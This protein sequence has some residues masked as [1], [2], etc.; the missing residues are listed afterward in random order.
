MKKVLV[1][2]PLLSQSGYGVHARQIFQFC[3]N[4]PDWEVYTQIL[5]WGITPWNISETDEGGI[6]NRIMSVS[7]APVAKFDISFQVQLPHEWDTSLADKNVG[8]TAGVETNLCSTEW[9]NT[10]RDKMDLLIVPSEFTKS[11]LKKCGS[12]S[13]KTPIVVLPEAYF[14][15][16]T[17]AP[18]SDPLAN[19]PTSKNILM[20][21][22]LT[23]DNADADRKNLVKSI[24]WF[25]NTFSGKP[26]VGL[27]VKT[28]RGR[29]TTIDREIVRKLMR[30]VKKSVA[31]TGPRAP[32]LYMLHGAMSRDE[33]RD[34]Y[35]SPKLT[36]YASATRG[37]GFGLPLLEAA[38]A[39]L[40]IVA[41][42]WSAHTEFL[43]GPSFLKV[44]Y[45]LQEIPPSRIDGNIF[46]KGAMWAQ[47]RGGNFCRKLKQSV[48]E[49]SGMRE[50][51]AALSEKLMSTHSIQALDKKFK[52]IVREYLDDLR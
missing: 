5:P 15:N 13:S 10:H 6:Y 19:L 1:R 16:L 37:E 29:D 12:A 36:A 22:T 42:G 23:S 34:L 27:I 33:M 21:G 32:R 14:G 3:E 38:V 51:A 35:K 2:G 31:S 50:H 20:V 30:Q 49:H 25:L 28:S 39:G 9:A 24:S 48:T 52:D 7:S 47:P 4:N 8:V 11:T 40:P 18:Q 17:D 45:D 44:A 46:V 41:T 26:D 43:S